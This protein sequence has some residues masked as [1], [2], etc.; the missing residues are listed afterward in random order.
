MTLLQCL[1]ALPWIA[2]AS[3]GEPVRFREQIAPILVS[4]CLG[5]HREGDAQG[6]L[7]MSTFARLREGG[8]IEGDLILLP[9][10]PEAS[11]LVAVLKPE[12]AIRMPLDQD[13]LTGSEIDLIARWVAEGADF[14]G[15]SEDMPLSSLVDPLARLPRVEVTA[16]VA[17]PV[18][19]V[20]FSRD[21]ARLAAARGSE[22]FLF[23]EDCGDPTHLLEGHEGE[24]NALVFSPDGRRLV[25]AGGRPGLLG[26]IAVWDAESGERL[27]SWGGHADTILSADL[28]PD[29]ATLATASYDRMV[30]L[31]DLDSG[32]AIRTLK[33]H[34][35]A[36]YAV[37]F[38]PG[39]ERLAS[40]SGDRT[41]K[42]WEA[43][44]GRRLESLGDATEE[45]YAV[46]FADEGS[47][48]LAG[49]ADRTIR[50]WRL[51]GDS[52]TLDRSAIAHDGAVLDLLVDPKGASL[53]STGEDGA[54][55]RW[56]L[57]D[58]APVAAWPRQPDWPL[59]AAVHPSGSPIALGRYDG[60]LVLL[61][62]SPG[63][64]ARGGGGLTLLD[65]AGAAEDPSTAAEEP[66]AAAPELVR[67]PSLGPPSP[68]GAERGRTVVVELGG[69]GVGLANAVAFDDPRLGA[70]IEP[71][72]SPDPDRLRIKVSIAEDAPIGRHLLRVQTPLGVPAAQGFA[73]YEAPERAEE[74][75]NGSVEQATPVGWPT[76][77]A[78]AIEAPGD[79][80]H[81][82]FPVAR[83]ETIVCADRGGSLGSAL[84][85][86]L[87]LR[88]DAGVVV[89]SGRSVVTH[90]ADRDGELTLRIADR[91]FNGSGNHFYRIEIGE[92]P[93]IDGVFPLG[94]ARGGSAELGV[95][96]ANLG[97]SV[98]SVSAPTTAGEPGTLL[99]VPATDRGGRP[100]EGRAKVVVAEGP[101]AVEVEPNDE[102]ASGPGL[103]VPGGVSGRIDRDGDRDHVKISAKAGHPLIVEVFGH[104]LG[105]EIDPV[106]EILDAE[107]APVP[108]AVLRPVARSSVAFRDHDATLDRI[109]LTQWDELAQ[110]DYLLIGRELTRLF[111]LPR[112][113]DDDA[114]FWSSGGRR[115]A[116]LGTTP[117]QHPQ[118]Q[119][120]DKVEI[121]PP[122]T[123]FPP[124]G[125]AP[126]T[127]VHRNDDATG[128]GK[129]AS[130][131][132][133]PPH[134]GTYLIR[135]G[136]ARGLG[137]PGFGY[138]LV[139]REPRP[140]FALSLGT[141]RPDIPRG[142]AAV[143]SA[144]VD[145]ID[146]FEAPIDLRVEGLPPGI[147][148]TSA[149]VEAG[150]GS[151]DLLLMADEDAPTFS[152]TPWRVVAEAARE[153]GS[154]GET[155]R[156]E[157]RPGGGRSS[158]ITVTPTPDLRVSTDRD[159]VVLRPG[160]HAEL[161]F[162]VDRS[163]AFSGRVPIDVRNLPH[164]VRVLDVGLNGVLI[165]ESQA[166]RTVVL[167]AEPWV[168]PTERP[169]F[170]VGKVEAA[171][172]DHSTPPIT[173]VI[174][175]GGRP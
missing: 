106:V 11:H 107:G 113:P 25:A 79:V 55:K 23:D 86:V 54:V 96:G 9:G 151:A 99:D 38:A 87:E 13:P 63:A 169:F 171:G 137:G 105:T 19:A 130:L 112:N 174:A 36:V 141:E 49:G 80:D 84:D 132:F 29:G 166:E 135:V 124:G 85:P 2:L 22:I 37:A 109:R 133:D 119:P 111:A 20:A 160:E 114:V 108:L 5:C 136:D 32:A 45:L 14:D 163:A 59:A 98:V 72:A 97:S 88:D 61:P 69:A 4:R 173:L 6:G 144:S 153:G 103:A 24:I 16:E 30:M 65:P 168:A 75:P 17:D 94:V 126:V 60:A 101:Q 57:P 164:G 66:G 152:S 44:T 53:L 15:E 7:D 140:D 12:A 28:A 26:S 92:I 155:I 128:L 46:A 170:G 149:R 159:R 121:H 120:I 172:T 129:D 27:R 122:G 40:A 76:T 82:R 157:I 1:A 8:A 148:A 70:A 165:T 34:T 139:V 154:A 74:E 125:A 73:V 150:H 100:A 162:R 81:A 39:G 146:G 95:S 33:E 115:R 21:G 51:S 161:T 50:R 71:S 104:R 93:R 77:L 158:W 3:D 156:H 147:R 167:Y 78:G 110:D 89:G 138:H 41:V 83:G 134:D 52:G 47:T 91:Q 31:W 123:T 62:G 127:L 118:D 131:R 143:V 64:D 117:E 116:Y 175:G 18:S 35:D 56:S 102:P 58:L 145:R 10:E 68:R 48:V 43:A 90:R 142:G 67:R 42:I